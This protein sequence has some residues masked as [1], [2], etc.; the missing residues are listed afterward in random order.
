MFGA[1]VAANVA[2][3]IVEV[4]ETNNMN[5]IAEQH[6]MFTTAGTSIPNHKAIVRSDNNSVL[7]VVGKGYEPVQNH[8]AF[9]FMDI[10]VQNHDA[11]YEYLYEIDGGSRLIVQAKIDS[12]FTVRRGDQISSYITMINSF[13]GSTPFKIFYTPIRL[14]C[15]N[16]LGGA[17]AKAK[18]SVSIRHTKNVAQRTE[19]AFE[20]LGMANDYFV[21]YKEQAKKLANKS[22]DKG[23]VDKFLE[24]VIG[25]PDSTRRQNQFDEIKE[26]I[27]SGKG[28][29]GESLWDAYNGVTEYVDHFRIK[30]DEKRLA[31][32]MVGSGA[33]IKEKAWQVAV[34]M[35]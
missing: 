6:E 34:K 20:I 35:S 24:E 29:K 5:W 28:N 10:L 33:G 17:I 2:N 1:K 30:N 31:S 23:L 21:A 16:Q 7:G 15:T 22:L 32:A 25:T 3:S 8:D 27:E 12:D 4:L 13:D 18:N 9:A 11:K 14:F 26:L 19:E